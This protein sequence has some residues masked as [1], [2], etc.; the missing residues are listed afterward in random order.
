M[1]VVTTT[2]PLYKYPEQKGWRYEARVIDLVARFVNS[3]PTDVG[4][5]PK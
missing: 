3:L 5:R 1:V 2:D 4:G